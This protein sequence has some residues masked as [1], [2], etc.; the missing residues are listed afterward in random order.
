MKIVGCLLLLGLLFLSQSKWSNTHTLNGDALKQVQDGA[1]IELYFTNHLDST[2]SVNSPIKTLLM[3]LELISTLMM[4]PR[5]LLHQ[6]MLSL[7]TKS[8][9]SMDW[10]T[11]DA[12]RIKTEL[13]L[14][15]NLIALAKSGKISFPND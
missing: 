2:V 7:L 3:L 10:R 12:T 11:P 9:R 13:L 1:R 5:E 6:L 8:S 14:V 4:T 15:M